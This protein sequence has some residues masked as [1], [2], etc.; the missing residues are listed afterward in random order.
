MSLNVLILNMDSVGEGLAFAVRCTKAGHSVRL[1]LSKENNMSTGSGFPGIEIIDNWV[2][3]IKWADLVFPTGNH[4][5]MP[6]LAAIKARGVDI[7]GP[8]PSSAGLEI[9]RSEGMEFLEDHGID[10]PEYKT[11]STLNDAE[12]FIRKDKGRWVFKTLGDEDDKALS[13]C[14]KSAADM[15][16]RIRHWQAIGLELK[17]PCMLQT[18]I[19]GI[20]FAVSR[21]MGTKGFI[22]KFNENFEHK[23]LLSGNVGPNCGETGTVQKYVDESALGEEM[24]LPLEKALIKMGHL[25]DIDVNCIIDNDG[26]AWPLEFTSRPGWP[27]FNIMLVEHIGDPVQWMLDACHGKDTLNCSDDVAVGVVIAQPDFP[28]S[29]LT[30]KHTDG[31]PINGINRKN[32]NY[33]HPQSIKVGKSAMMEGEEIKESDAWLTT[34]DYIAVV[35][36]TGDSVQKATKRAYN[37]VKQLHVPDMIYRDDIGEDLGPKIENLQNYGYATEWEF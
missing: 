5:L 29:K 1:W 34:G 17:G 30:K 2:A 18:F 32:Q 36:G 37:T 16:E 14:S 28:Y 15:V 7:Y 11:F 20:E 13:Y 3:S 22:G 35:T 8:S 19:D 24:L 9:K 25:G 6:R 23:K 27:A 33:I 12:S 21:W 31:M 10:V 26:R 4:D